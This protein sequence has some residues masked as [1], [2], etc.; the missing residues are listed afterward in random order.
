MKIEGLK[1]LKQIV[2]L[3]RDQGVSSIEV[4]GIKL[5][6]GPAPKPEYKPQEQV[7][8]PLENAQVPTY[9]PVHQE[10]AQ[11]TAARLTKE[12]GM[13]EEQLLHWSA[14]GPTD[15]IVSEQ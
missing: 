8:D 2:K 15:H 10:S 13:T 3:C 11:E 7:I 12:A 9:T 4:D 14:V 1:D 6:L 5:T